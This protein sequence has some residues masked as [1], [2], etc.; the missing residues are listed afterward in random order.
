MDEVLEI[1]Y[2]LNNVNQADVLRKIPVIFAP[3][4]VVSPSIF[5]IPLKAT[6]ISR[7]R[8]DEIFS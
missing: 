6:P 4:K 8:G 3:I 2:S 7:F 1:I 5:Q